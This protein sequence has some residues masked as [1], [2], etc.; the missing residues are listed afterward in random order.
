[1]KILK[2]FVYDE[3]LHVG[4]SNKS[5]IHSLLLFFSLFFLLIYDFDIMYVF[6]LE[7]QDF[8]ILFGFCICV[9]F[10]CR[11]LGKE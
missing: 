3:F 4:S 1:M 9:I 5:K 7:D 11:L 6:V 10:M 2:G 8:E